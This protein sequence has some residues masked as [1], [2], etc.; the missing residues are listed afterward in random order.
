MA[1]QLIRQTGATSDGKPVIAFFPIVDTHGIPLS[2]AVSQ[3][4][5]KGMM[6]D[7]VD[8]YIEATAHG[9]SES[10]TYVQMEAAATDNFGPAFMEGWRPRM[11][12]IRAMLPAKGDMPHPF[13]PIETLNAYRAGTLSLEAASKLVVDKVTGM[14]VHPDIAVY[15]LTAQ[16]K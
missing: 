5:D 1:K 8:F 9:W 15:M 4:V 11:Q 2:M 6:P 3:L 16:T 13:L 12:L 7:W 10:N 14:P